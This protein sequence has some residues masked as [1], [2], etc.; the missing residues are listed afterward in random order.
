M[1]IWLTWRIAA[2]KWVVAEY[3]KEKWFEYFTVS[4]MVREEA[5][6][7]WVEITR[8]NLQTIGNEIRAECWLWAWMKRILE[9]MQP[10]KD[11]LIDGIRNPWEVL[12]LQK[13]KDFYLFSIDADQELRFERV[14]SRSKE[15]DPKT[16]EKFLEIDNRDFGIWEPQDGQQVGKCM[17]MANFHI[18]NNGDLEEYIHQINTSFNSIK[19]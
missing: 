15:S 18:Q 3:M 2:G 1:I 5:A 16:R 10:D 19:A 9:R 8:Y 4:Q 13:T 7:R 17:E 14:L 11:Y 12:E 6:K